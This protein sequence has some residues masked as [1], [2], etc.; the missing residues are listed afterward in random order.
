MDMYKVLRC[1]GVCRVQDFRAWIT[2]DCSAGVSDSREH[3]VQRSFGC[4]SC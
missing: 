3:G 1:V 2:D 4:R